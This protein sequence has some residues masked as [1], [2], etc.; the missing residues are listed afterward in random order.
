MSVKTKKEKKNSG[1]VSETKDIKL[2]FP[3]CIDTNPRT[4]SLVMNFD[5]GPSR[6]IHRHALGP[7]TDDEDGGMCLDMAPMW[8]LEEE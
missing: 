1:H 7:P 2:L 4:G 6:D 5:D 3:C 8:C